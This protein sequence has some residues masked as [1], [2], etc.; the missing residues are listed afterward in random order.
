[1]AAENQC[2]VVEDFLTFP[3]QPTC[4]QLR[5][6]SFTS[7]RKETA[8]GRR[9]GL[10]EQS[11]S[12]TFH[13]EGGERRGR[14]QSYDLSNEGS[15]S[16]QGLPVRRRLQELLPGDGRQGERNGWERLQSIRRRLQ[17]KRRREEKEN[18]VETVTAM[19]DEEGR[20]GNVWLLDEMRGNLRRGES[21]REEG[22]EEDFEMWQESDF[23]MRQGSDFEMRQGSDFEMRQGRERRQLMRSTS[24][25]APLSLRPAF[26]RTSSFTLN[27]RRL[28]LGGL[29]RELLSPSLPFR[30]SSISNGSSTPSSMN[31]SG[32]STPSSVENSSS[33]SEHFWNQYRRSPPPISI[34]D[35]LKSIFK[36]K[37][38]RRR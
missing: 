18:A 1:M 13:S 4:F 36:G 17:E 29:K 23:E 16:K 31:S 11:Q 37:L 7:P 20:G 19:P 25:T 2:Y 21:V 35:M 30:P 27:S 24:L 32:S 9:T 38:R 26:P 28:P 12:F 5:S 8:G 14:R 6:Q 10:Q 34:P 33:D 15:R 3:Y 22:S